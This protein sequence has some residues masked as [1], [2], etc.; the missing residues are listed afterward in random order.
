MSWTTHT[1]RFQ[2]VEHRAQKN[3]PCPDCGKKV[4]RS[5]TFEQT[6]NPWNKNAAGDP[7]TV[8]EIREELAADA[9]AWREK[10][11]QC[12]ACIEASGDGAA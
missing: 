3:L 4:R 9:A 1:V 2:E 12:K 8:T 5:T 10:P 6:I 7:K 11:V